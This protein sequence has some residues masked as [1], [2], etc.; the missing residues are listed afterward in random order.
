MCVTHPIGVAPFMLELMSNRRL[1]SI[2][3]MGPANMTNMGPAKVKR[4]MS[5]RTHSSYWSIRSDRGRVNLKTAS[6]IIWDTCSTADCCPLLSIVVN[7][8]Q[9]LFI[10]VHF[11]PLLSIMVLCC[12]LLSIVVHCYPLLS[13][14]IHCCLL[15]LSTADIIYCF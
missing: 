14:V 1:I 15:L 3:N 6:E 4:H 13:I 10:V 12:P 9:L 8:C 2:T 5:E 7:C 11:Y